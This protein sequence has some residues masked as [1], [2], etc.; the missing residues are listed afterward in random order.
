MN[1]PS[2]LLITAATGALLL[3]AL[4][5]SPSALTAVRGVVAP[6]VTPSEEE[7]DELSLEPMNR[8]FLMGLTIAELGQAWRSTHHQLKSAHSAPELPAYAR[9]RQMVLEELEQRNPRD[10]N[11]WLSAGGDAAEAPAA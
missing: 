11:E 5:S 4:L 8:D 10:V 9:L 3:L 7:L 2:A 1:H 6:L